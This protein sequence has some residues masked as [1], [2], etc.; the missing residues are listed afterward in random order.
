M[1]KDIF[2]MMSP[3][4]NEFIEYGRVYQKYHN[5]ELVF[6]KAGCFD[7]AKM[8]DSAARPNDVTPSKMY[9]MF[10]GHYS[11]TSQFGQEHLTAKEFVER[12]YQYHFPFDQVDK[13]Y[14][15]GCEIGLN[16]SEEKITYAQQVAEEIQVRHPTISIIA[17]NHSA[18]YNDL[19]TINI[20][21]PIV[22]SVK[23]N[24]DTKK[25]EP[26]LAPHF[27]ATGVKQAA[28]DAISKSALEKFNKDYEIRFDEAKSRIQTAY[29]EVK[30]KLAVISGSFNTSVPTGEM[31]SVMYH[32]NLSK[33]INDF[34]TQLNNENNRLQDPGAS[35][36]SKISNQLDEISKKV[37][38]TD[39]FNKKF[40][41]VVSQ[42][43]NS[44]AED[45]QKEL[46]HDYNVKL[47]A[48]VD[49]AHEQI[50]PIPDT[51]PRSSDGYDDDSPSFEVKQYLDSN[52]N[53]EFS[54]KNM[55]TIKSLDA[56]RLKA[57]RVINN[58]ISACK[59]SSAA[60]SVKNHTLA[61]LHDLRKDVED[62]HNHFPTIMDRL[63]SEMPS[64]SSADQL[65]LIKIRDALQQEHTLSAT[66]TGLS[67][68]TGLK[69][70]DTPDQK[71][72]T[73]QTTQNSQWRLT[74]QNLLKLGS[75]ILLPPQEIQS[76]S[77]HRQDLMREFK[78]YLNELSETE[79]RNCFQ[80]VLDKRNQLGII[81]QPPEI[82]SASFFKAVENNG[83]AE[84]EK[85]RE[86]LKIHL[87]IP[88]I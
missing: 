86:E 85:I 23:F 14:L 71:L 7:S 81:L 37:D 41:E 58:S 46:D 45:I 56:N 18:Y 79:R 77:S 66:D 52:P 62:V 6:F 64:Y 74:L 73:S 68:A 49:G 83:R 50:A 25:S 47:E 69:K 44:L 67:A 8:V 51:V 80:D 33:I 59:I 40:D 61:F 39:T 82:T 87:D 70:E 27:R 84:L 63:I 34:K 26:C 31:A 78:A 53:F 32:D 76:L 38:N 3:E 29:Q 16:T 22:S 20:S 9:A 65:Q 35:E 4:E 43:L 55:D 17:F 12:L 10:D 21:G 36:Y 54:K 15:N 48:K 88:R 72:A 19:Y 28:Y 13:I 1:P 11:R 5:T 57:W 75:H 42:L 2:I 24:P 30:Q 60:E